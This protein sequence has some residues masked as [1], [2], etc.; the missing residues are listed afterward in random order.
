MPFSD[1]RKEHTLVLGAALAPVIAY[2]ALTVL[3]GG[4]PLRCQNSGSKPGYIDRDPQSRAQAPTDD[5]SRSV[6]NGSYKQ[7]N[8]QKPENGQAYE[9]CQQWRSA[10]A[11]EEQACLARRQF[12]LGILSVFGLL[13]TII[14]AGK[15]AQAIVDNE[16]PWVGVET[17][18]SERIG[19]SNRDFSARVVIKNTGHTPA[20]DMKAKFI[21]HIT[22]PDACPAEPDLSEVPSKPLLSTVLDFYHPFADQGPLSQTDV[23]A[24]FA[25]EKDAWIVGR[26][27][28]SSERSDKR[29]RTRVCTRWDKSLN[30][31]VPYKGGND[32]T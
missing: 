15:Q 12:W 29:H 23:D 2:V 13:G 14:Y 28:Y 19:Q 7:L 16:R 5:Q 31:F 10:E 4:D 24:L 27:E 6:L 32:A 25:G 22:Q 20:F 3:A 11:A 1:W 17:V 9:R 18:S 21:G 30:A 8:C 26:I